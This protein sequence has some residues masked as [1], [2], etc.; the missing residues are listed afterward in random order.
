MSARQ[1]YPK[2]HA[3]T[4]GP[5][6]QGETSRQTQDALD[7]IDRLR[8][9]NHELVCRANDM[10]HL[11][12]LMPDNERQIHERWKASHDRTTDDLAE[13]VAALEAVSCPTVGIKP[14]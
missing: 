10:N 5:H 12:V 11:G 14:A 13:R 6:H 7:E 4:S 8:K 9:I 3:N 1:D 2:A